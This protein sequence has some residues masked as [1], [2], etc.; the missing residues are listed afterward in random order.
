[1][2]SFQNRFSGMIIR[3]L[4]I[5]NISINQ[6]SKK[7]G[8][9]QG[10]LSRVLKGE[11]NITSNETILKIAKELN[12]NPPEEL[13]IELGRLPKG[14]KE[15]VDLAILA[16]RL[17]ALQLRDLKDRALNMDRKNKLQKAFKKGQKNE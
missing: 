16:N 17:N 5:F 6:L 12:I 7:V 4:G 15:L 11:R 3:N 10:Y 8:I 14:K 9:N 13:L 1:M 2:N